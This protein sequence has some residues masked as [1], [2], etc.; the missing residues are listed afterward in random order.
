MNL[1]MMLHKSV[2]GCSEF[3]SGM[4]SEQDGT[5]NL[6]FF[7]ACQFESYRSMHGHVWDIWK[8]SQIHVKPPKNIFYGM[9]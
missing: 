2:L 7:L 5:L 1:V 6:T 8:S 9:C 3:F 4:Q